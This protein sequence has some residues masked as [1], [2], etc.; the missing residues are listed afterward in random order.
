[1]DLRVLIHIYESPEHAASPSYPV[2]VCQRIHVYYV[3]VDVGVD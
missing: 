2:A 1:M 3:A